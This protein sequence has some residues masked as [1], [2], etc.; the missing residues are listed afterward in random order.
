MG[1]KYFV[2]RTDLSKANVH[3]F[4]DL[5]LL[6]L[7]EFTN[8]LFQWKPGERKLSGSPKSQNIVT[9]IVL[10][11][12]QSCSTGKISHDTQQCSYFGTSKRRWR[13]TEV[14]LNNPKI[15]SSSCRCTTTSIPERQETKK[16]CISNSSEAAA[17]ARRFPKGHRSFLG[18]RNRKTWYGTHTHTSQTVCKQFCGD[19]DVHLRGRGTPYIP[20]NKRVGPR[21]FEK[22]TRRKNVDAPQR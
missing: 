2:E 16:P 20:R 3:V 4:S 5:V 7:A 11:E 6:S 22:Q 19:D 17:C 14:S 13:K 21:P 8:F 10:T 9:W 15:E 1:E 18:T 12:N